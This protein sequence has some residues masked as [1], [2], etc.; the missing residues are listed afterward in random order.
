MTRLSVK[1]TGTPAPGY[2][3][4]LGLDPGPDAAEGVALEIMARTT[5]GDSSWLSL[6][7]SSPSPYGQL[8]G[9]LDDS[10][11]WGIGGYA[12]GHPLVVHARY[13]DISSPAVPL[14]GGVAN[15]TAVLHVYYH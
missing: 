13:V 5:H 11:T 4:L 1:L 15:A 3:H 14:K 7:A 9:R 2:P 8:L 6:P 12:S 10:A